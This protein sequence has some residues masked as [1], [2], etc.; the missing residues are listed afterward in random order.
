MTNDS[1][2]LTIKG[3]NEDKVSFANSNNWTK[4]T[5]ANNG[6]FEYTNTTDTSVKVKVE[7]NIND[8]AIL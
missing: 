2:E 3:T 6:Y 4:S 1:G 5:T 7:T 8:Q